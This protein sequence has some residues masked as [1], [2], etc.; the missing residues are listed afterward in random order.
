MAE[1]IS[2]ACIKI[3]QERN[4]VVPKSIPINM[5]G[6]TPWGFAN[7]SV[8]LS[9]LLKVSDNIVG[10]RLGVLCTRCRDGWGA[11]RGM[12]LVGRLNRGEGDR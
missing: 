10:I 2:F 11:D 8:A 1:L 6:V 12:G 9:D 5:V 3:G 4:Y 7:C